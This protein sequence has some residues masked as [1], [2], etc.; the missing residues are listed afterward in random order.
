MAV[1]K[2]ALRRWAPAKPTVVFDAYWR[3][4][5]ERQAVF[6]RRLERQPPPWTN[7]PVLRR[8]KFTNA[9]RILDRVSQYLVRNV[10]YS[11]VQNGSCQAE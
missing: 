3:F 4:A 6:F 5:T 9:Y 10:M 7:D 8:F 1:Q 2:E 11:G